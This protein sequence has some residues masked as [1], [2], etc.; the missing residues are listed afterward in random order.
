LIGLFYSGLT[1][2]LLFLPEVSFDFAASGDIAIA[3]KN[4]LNDNPG[5]EFNDRYYNRL[6]DL[7]ND[8]NAEF[9]TIA[10]QVWQP[11]IQHLESQEA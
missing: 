6:F 9:E 11:M 1:K 10:I 5:T 8:L 2:P 7:P 4:F 3:R